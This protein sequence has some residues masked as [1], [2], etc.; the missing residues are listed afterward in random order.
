MNHTP[1]PWS[2]SGQLIVGSPEPVPNPKVAPY[3][4]TVASIC[5]DY[6]GDTNPPEPRIKWN[7]EGLANAQLIAAAPDLLKGCQAAMAYLAD[8]RSK[9]K[10]NR[11]VAADFI[12][13]AIAKALG[14]TP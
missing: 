8:P 3:G 5:W 9:F 13:A 12:R 14:E 4:K 2:M 1:G 11:D 10:V 6:C 7:K